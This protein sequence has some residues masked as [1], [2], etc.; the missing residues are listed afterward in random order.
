LDFNDSS[1]QIGVVVRNGSDISWFS[2]ASATKSVGCLIIL[3][4]ITV[5]ILFFL[6]EAEFPSVII[7]PVLKYVFVNFCGRQFYYFFASSF[8]CNLWIE[9]FHLVTTF[10]AISVSLLPSIIKVPVCLLR[11]FPYN[12]NDF[13]DGLNC[14]LFQDV[15]KI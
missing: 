9:P 4:Q 7:A 2:G 5:G 15:L 13:T 6:Y 8:G 10:I 1:I 11:F 3:N 12:T 14:D